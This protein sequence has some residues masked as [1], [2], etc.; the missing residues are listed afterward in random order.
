MSPE[1]QPEDR[2]SGGESGGKTQTDVWWED[3]EWEQVGHGERGIREEG[4]LTRA[5]TA[6]RSR[7]IRTGKV[8]TQPGSKGGI[9]AVV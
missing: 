9:T 1:G 8:S 3:Q 6:E 5:Q 7:K 4:V 2:E